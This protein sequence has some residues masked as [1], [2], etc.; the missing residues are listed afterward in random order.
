M[1]KFNAVVLTAADGTQVH[2][3][4]RGRAKTPMMDEIVEYLNENGIVLIDLE[5]EAKAE[6]AALVNWAPANNKLFLKELREGL[7]W[8]SSKYG[9]SEHVI[10]SYIKAKM[11]HINE[12]F[13]KRRLVD[14]Q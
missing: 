4:T 3:V 11:P 5:A 2:F 9:V 14:G 6:E 7:T 12:S 10:E 8:C 1:S 13:Y